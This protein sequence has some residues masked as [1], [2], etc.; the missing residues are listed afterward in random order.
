MRSSQHQVFGLGDGKA[1]ANELGFF[2]FDGLLGFGCRLDFGGGC[3]FG[4]DFVLVWTWPQGLASKRS[5]S[6]PMRGVALIGFAGLLTAL[7]MVATGAEGVAPAAIGDAV[8][9]TVLWTVV[10]GLVF[11]IEFQLLFKR[12]YIVYM[13]S[14]VTQNLLHLRRQTAYL[15]GL[16]ASSS[17]HLHPVN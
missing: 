5:W 3:S 14:R 9:L 2:L 13:V 15:L 4:V 17:E 7:A 6:C 11:V 1:V 16:A 12:F 10:S 8:I